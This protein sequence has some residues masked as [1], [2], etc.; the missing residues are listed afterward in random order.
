MT[1]IRTLI[2]DDEPAARRGIRLLARGDPDV[3]IVGECADGLEALRTIEKE[4]PDL[5][6]LDIQMPGLD[7]FGVLERLNTSRMPYIVF[8]TAYDRYAIQAFDVHAVDYLLKP[9]SDARFREA[10]DQAKARVRS[11]DLDEIRE[12]IASLKR[13]EERRAGAPDGAATPRRLAVPDGEGVVLV[14]VPG[15]RWVEAQKDYAALHTDGRTWL[16]RATIRDL[17]RS[18]D[19]DLFVRIHRSTIVNLDAV[20]E[21][22]PLFRGEC[23]VRLDDGTELRVS[24]RRRGALAAALHQPL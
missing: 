15:I 1:A 12:W 7:G 3:E 17:H 14:D 2:I 18:L 4:G 19:P 11:Q 6:F 23:V 5:I 22:R 8:V 13:R 10:L 21:V 16:V 9:F 24:R 20:R